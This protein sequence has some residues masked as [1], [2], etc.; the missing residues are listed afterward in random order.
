M[1]NDNLT[2]TDFYF[3]LMLLLWAMGSY[4]PTII[5]AILAGYGLYKETR[6]K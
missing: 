1:R 5:C 4:L 3:G 2:G 6:S